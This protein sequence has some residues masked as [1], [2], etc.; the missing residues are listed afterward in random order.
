L[1]FGAFLGQ[2]VCG[3]EGEKSKGISPLWEGLLTNLWGA[4]K[5]GGREPWPK[6]GL[7]K[8]RGAQ[9]KKSLGGKKEGGR[10]APL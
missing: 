1:I 2:L 10:E 3:G 5:L 4:P 9:I 6:G 8:W 7:Q